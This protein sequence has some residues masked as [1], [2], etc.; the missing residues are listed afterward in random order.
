MISRFELATR[1]EKCAEKQDIASGLE[2][3]AAFVGAEHYLL[4][5]YDV[6]SEDGYD[7]VVAADWP[8]DLVRSLGA[9][10]T[11]LHAKRNEVDRCMASME[12]DFQAAGAA[13]RLPSHLSAQYCAIP[14]DTGHARLVMVLLFRNDIVAARDRLYDMA[15]IA[16]YFAG[17]FPQA[18]YVPDSMLDLTEREIECLNWIAEGKTSD[19]ISMIIG[20]SR[21]TVNNYI[22]SIMRKTATKTRSEAIAYAVRNSLI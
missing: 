2:F 1:L 21:N 12:P 14:F 5:R 22:T 3:L 19:E 6:F 9:H 7:Y 8:F 18:A 15:L 11:R 4:A 13:I 16:A 17:R 20:I 10:V